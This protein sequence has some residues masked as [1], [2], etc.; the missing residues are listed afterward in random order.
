MAMVQELG[1]DAIRS[2]TKAEGWLRGGNRQ[3]CLSLRAKP[4]L[5]SGGE[6]DSLSV[7][8]LFA[9]EQRYRF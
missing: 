3:L 6:D 4:W 9:E 5:M 8:G 7:M 1:N 2:A